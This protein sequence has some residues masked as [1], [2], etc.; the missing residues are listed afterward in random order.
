MNDM[1]TWNMIAFV[2][3]L[4]LLDLWTYFNRSKG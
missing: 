3:I 4:L 2:A 1:S